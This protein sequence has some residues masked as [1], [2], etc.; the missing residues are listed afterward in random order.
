M[1]I[2]IGIGIGIAVGLV[3]L[4]WLA[5]FGTSKYRRW[6]KEAKKEVPTSW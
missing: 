6:A 4:I 3:Y 2:I 1:D 5:T